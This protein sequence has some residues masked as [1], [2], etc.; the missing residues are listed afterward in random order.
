[1][2]K[3]VFIALALVVLF[4]ALGLGFIFYF[5]RTV[6]K[7]NPAEEKQE[8]FVYYENQEW[9]FGFSYPAEWQKQPTIQ[10]EGIT[11][12]KVAVPEA[13]FSI[14]A[15]NPGP[16]QVFEE[17]IQNSVQQLQGAGLFISQSDAE[18]AGYNAEEIVYFDNSAP[19]NKQQRYF[20][21]RGSIWYQIVYSATQEKFDQYLP[22]AEGMIASIKI[23]K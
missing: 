2:K 17:E 18:I 8:E 22:Q 10:K 13:N 23:T 14:L 7:N 4:V 11:S 3:Y 12:F 19:Q 5:S 9:G 20:I 1:M 16:S 6:N 15:F 21:D